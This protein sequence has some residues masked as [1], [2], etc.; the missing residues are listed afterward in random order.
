MLT[1]AVFCTETKMVA[2][3]LLSMNTAP[4]AV[5]VPTLTGLVAVLICWTL[6]TGVVATVTKSVAV[7]ALLTNTT[8]VAVQLPTDTGEVDV[9]ICC[10]LNTGV[11]ATV[12]GI[13]AADDIA[14]F[15]LVAVGWMTEIEPVAAAIW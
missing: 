8:P 7:P 3:A 10:T 1:V 13:V 14:T 15:R 12:T 6:N 11:V 9:L 2:V 4:V 5:Q